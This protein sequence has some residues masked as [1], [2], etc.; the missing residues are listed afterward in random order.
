MLSK[1]CGGSFDCN[2]SFVVVDVGSL[3]LTG[4]AANGLS[5]TTG[6]GGGNTGDMSKDSSGRGSFSVG[7]GA[8]AGA[9]AGT[10][11]TEDDDVDT[12]NGGSFAT[13]ACGM[14]GDG[15][16]A[17]S[18]AVLDRFDALFLVD[19]GVVD[20]AVRFRF[21]VSIFSIKDDFFTWPLLLLMLLFSKTKEGE[22]ER[23]KFEKMS[24]CVLLPAEGNTLC[25][26]LLSVD[27]LP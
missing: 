22:D 7:G 15:V 10:L 25:R 1:D 27:L 9:G 20:V 4:M 13:V 14:V 24:T 2:G 26:V 17:L 12:A 8:G 21:G 19:V 11:D 18:L 3:N 5:R 6:S 16:A 23:S